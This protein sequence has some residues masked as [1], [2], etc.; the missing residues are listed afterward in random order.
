MIHDLPSRAS[1]ARMLGRAPT[2]KEEYLDRQDG[3]AAF[4]H[5]SMCARAEGLTLVEYL[6]KHGR[7]VPPWMGK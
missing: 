1:L 3:E 5:L 4:V 7:E 2:W 6:R